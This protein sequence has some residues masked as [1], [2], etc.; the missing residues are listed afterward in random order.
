MFPVPWTTMDLY[1]YSIVTAKLQ[2]DP[3][4]AVVDLAAARCA[5]PAA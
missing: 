5:I 4:A 1:S 3:S 2:A